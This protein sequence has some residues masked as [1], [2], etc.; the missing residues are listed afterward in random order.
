MQGRKKSEHRQRRTNRKKPV[1][2]PTKQ[3]LR[4]FLRVFLPTLVI[5]NLYIKYD[6]YMLNS[7]GDIFDGM[8][9]RER[10]KNT[11]KNK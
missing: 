5:V 1:L 3:H 11:A 6:V 7:Y 4:Q 10:K 2:F 8:I 9:W